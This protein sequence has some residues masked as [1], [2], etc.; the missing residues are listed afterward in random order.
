MAQRIGEAAGHPVP[1]DHPRAGLDRAQE[2]GGRRVIVRRS[3]RGTRHAP[4][5]PELIMGFL[6]LYLCPK[7]AESP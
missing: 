5:L 7:R 2:F 6:P 4:T 1:G 3:I